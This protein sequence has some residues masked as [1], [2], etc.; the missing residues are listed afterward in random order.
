MTAIATRHCYPAAAASERPSHW[1]YWGRA[2]YVSRRDYWKIFLAFIAV[3][4]PLGAGGILG[5]WAIP[6][7]A[8]FV[9][10]AIGLA[11]L[12]YSLV[13]LYRMYGHPSLPYYRQ[14]LALGEVADG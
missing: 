2:L 9:V 1:W 14:L 12:A 13:G 4:V 8:A 6:L 3:G 10:A 11:L 7:D 5:G